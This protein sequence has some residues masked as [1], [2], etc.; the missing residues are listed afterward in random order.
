M[1]SINLSLFQNM[2]KLLLSALLL[3]AGNAVSLARVGQVDVLLSDES[4]LRLFTDVQENSIKAKLIAKRQ[5][6]VYIEPTLSRNLNAADEYFLIGNRTI[7]QQQRQYLLLVT[8]TPS[9]PNSK[10]A[11]AC[12]A[13]TEDTLRLVEWLPKSHRLVQRDALLI[14]SCLAPLSL[15]DDSGT[16]LR[17]RMESITTTDKLQLTWLE[18]PKFGAS[19]K[20]IIIKDGVLVIQ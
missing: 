3:I 13:G 7:Q 5:S 9:K 10:G 1:A 14:Q 2:L 8:L 17:K 19:T 6:I 11:G 15:N 20:E 16:T 12:G 4:S 18:H